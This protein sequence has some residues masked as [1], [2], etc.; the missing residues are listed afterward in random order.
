MN[1]ANYHLSLYLNKHKKGS[2]TSL[3][4][5][6]EFEIDKCSVDSLCMLS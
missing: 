2:R 6:L 5:D 4:P 3:E 1:K